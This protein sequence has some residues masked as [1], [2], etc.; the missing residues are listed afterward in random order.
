MDK[1]LFIAIELHSN[2]VLE[3]VINEFKKAFAP[4]N[5]KWV[6]TAQMHL[7]LEFLGDTDEKNI[8]QII[9]AIIR[10][11]AGIA[12]FN[13]TIAGAGV[14]KSVYNPT[15]LW[16]GAQ[17]SAPLEK[18]KYMLGA[19]LKELNFQTEERAFKPH[20]TLGRV[21]QFNNVG[22]LKMMLA[23]YHEKLVAQDVIGE[24]TLFESILTQ[25]GPLYRKLYIQKLEKPLL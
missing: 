15:V 8:P 22:L 14:F 10:S 25:Q 24:V 13:L 11:C 4:D 2:P 16:L 1:R 17:Q 19:C 5:I 20:L 23:K 12:P 3:T 6:N 9:D 21:K 7:T 18:I